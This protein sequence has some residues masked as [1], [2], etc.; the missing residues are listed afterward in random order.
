MRCPLHLPEH[1]C[2]VKRVGRKGSYGSGRRGQRA[3]RRSD[4][5]GA[6]RRWRGSARVKLGAGRRRGRP[7]AEQEACAARPQGD[8]DFWD[9]GRQSCDGRG[10]GMGQGFG[11]VRAVGRWPRGP[12]SPA[13]CR[14]AGIKGAVKLICGAV[15]FL[16]WINICHVK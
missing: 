6:G 15:L 13:P 12:R 10:A 7:A 5:E 2:A 16:C 11:P 4:A 3:S 9:F 14:V 1:G 8:G